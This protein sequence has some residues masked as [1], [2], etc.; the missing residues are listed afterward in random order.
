MLFFLAN[1]PATSVRAA[2]AANAA[3]PALA[4]QLLARDTETGVRRVLARKLAA[5][6]P[7]LDPEATER[8]RRIHWET[9]LQLVQDVAVPVRAAIADLVAEQPDV[10]RPLILRL[11][12]DIAMAVAEP[13]IRGSPLL[14]EADLIW[15]VAKPP[16]PET[17][18]AVA[19][20]PNLPEGP[21]DALAERA[22]GPSVA[23]LL[24]NAT[25]RLRE[26]TL[27]AIADGCAA[28]KS[29]QAALVRR[30]GLSE[31]VLRRLSG[32]LAEE[33]LRSLLAR[34]DIDKE[35]LGAAPGAA[36][37][38]AASGAMDEAS[39]V[40]AARRGGVSDCARILAALC[41]LPA[42]VVLRALERREAPAIVSLCWKAG[43]SPSTAVFA[44]MRLAGSKAEELLIQPG[45]I[46]AMDKDLMRRHV[47]RLLATA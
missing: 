22:D 10:P 23:A 15:L 30:P 1:D 2:I 32:L 4:D 9:L 7:L 13:V 11:A 33:A 36:A 27:V 29:W 12:H 44:Q 34:P 46:W 26:E 38:A 43:L 31:A 3:T 40:A 37:P 45:G 20:R 28:Q 35:A 16:V 5:L 18:V 17:L 24:A 19:R 6:A 8:H 21:S 47:E 14:E 42:G 41:G 25:A 39:F